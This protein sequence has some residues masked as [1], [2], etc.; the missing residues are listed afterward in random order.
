MNAT[1][2]SYQYKPRTSYPYRSSKPKPLATDD[3]KHPVREEIDRCIS[4]NIP[5][6]IS[7][8]EDQ[9][10]LNALKVPGMISFL[11]VLKRGDRKVSE[12]R[13]SAI[14]N[15][16]NK[17]IERSIHSAYNASIVDC[18]VRASKIDVLLPELALPS[19]DLGVI[20]PQEFVANEP[21]AESYA[22]TAKQKSLLISLIYQRVDDED[23]RERRLQEVESC[24][25]AD[26]SDL[27]KSMMAVQ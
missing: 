18:L 1:A 16:Y 6:T 11:A 23:E 22:I 13:G 8:E 15:R 9:A 26:A 3:R 20:V 19:Q 24:S 7:V 4:S 27:I 14:L 21:S 2:T 25:K 10:T 17:Y 12:G 5:F